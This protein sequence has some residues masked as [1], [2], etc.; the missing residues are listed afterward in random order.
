MKTPSIKAKVETTFRSIFEGNG[1]KRRE[2]GIYTQETGE[3]FSFWIGLPN[4]VKSGVAAVSPVIGLR[5]LETH[6]LL[7]QL[8]RD[9]A[10]HPYLPPTVSRGLGFLL[11]EAKWREWYFDLEDGRSVYEN[12]SG[13]IQQFAMPFFQ[14]RAKLDAIAELLEGYDFVHFKTERYQR[15]SVVNFLN[16]DLDKASQCLEEFLEY[17]KTY[18]TLQAKSD[19]MK[20]AEGLRGKI[21]GRG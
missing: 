20:F 12:M 3:G 5:H 1:F 14:R 11:P 4:S 9:E 16:G 21:F 7:S 19:A 8:L 6:E 13:L 15:L 17:A 2:S 18:P 10:S